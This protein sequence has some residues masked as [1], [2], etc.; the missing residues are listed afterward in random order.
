MAV[1]EYLT[2]FQRKK[3]GIC[4]TWLSSVGDDSEVVPIWFAKGTMKLPQPQP[5]SSVPPPVIMVGPGTG[6]AAF[7]SFIHHLSAKHPSMKII[8]IFGCRSEQKDY[9]YADE[10]QQIQNLQV[11]TAFSRA[12]EDGSKTYVHHV[13]RKV[14]GPS[15]ASLI[16]NEGAHIYVSG[17]AKNMPKSVEKAFIDIIKEHHLSGEEEKA[18]AYIMEMRRTGRY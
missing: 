16:Y 14:G 4:S 6:V 5:T 17:K 2:T 10:W 11:I 13:I 15:L 8:L 7:R 12:N 3:K 9:Y 18:K 1:T